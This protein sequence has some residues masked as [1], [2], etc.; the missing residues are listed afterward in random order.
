MISKNDLILIPM[1]AVLIFVGGV[2]L[3]IFAGYTVGRVC[4]PS[5]ENEDPTG[6]KKQ[7]L[8]DTLQHIKSDLEQ[9]VS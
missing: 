4:Y 6:E 3:G 8:Y 9:T 5:T 1:D 2:V 7:K